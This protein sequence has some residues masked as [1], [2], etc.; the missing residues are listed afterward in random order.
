MGREEAEPLGDTLKCS[1]TLLL[2]CI[3]NRNI[4]NTQRRSVPFTPQ[5]LGWFRCC[6]LGKRVIVVQAAPKEC[7]VT[8]TC[9]GPGGTMSASS[10]MDDGSFSDP[11]W[12]GEMDRGDES[13]SEHE[14][15]HELC[16]GQPNSSQRQWDHQHSQGR[17]CNTGWLVQPGNAHK[18][19]MPQDKDPSF[20]FCR[21]HH[22]WRMTTMTTSPQKSLST[23]SHFQSHC[24]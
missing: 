17:L 13:N 19:W 21:R 7:T 20:Q 8:D 2:R 16:D 4:R 1:P 15:G 6:T 24:P 12:R 3:R 18:T 23:T 11:M 9:V 10:R 14:Y 22:V 5:N